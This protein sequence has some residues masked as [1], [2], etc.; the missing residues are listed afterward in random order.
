MLMGLNANHDVDQNQAFL[1]TVM[2]VNDSINRVPKTK[3]IE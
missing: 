3:E 2:Q 1:T